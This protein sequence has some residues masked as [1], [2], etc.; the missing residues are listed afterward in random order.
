M[1]LFPAGP[2]RSFHLKSVTSR[3]QRGEDRDLRAAPMQAAR[4]PESLFLGREKPN[5]A[6]NEHRGR[7]ASTHDS[8]CPFPQGG[9]PRSPARACP[10]AGHVP[11]RHGGARDRQN[12]APRPSTT[13]LRRLVVGVGPPCKSSNVDELADESRASHVGRV[14]F[15]VR[16]RRTVTCSTGLARRS[17]SEPYVRCHPVLGGCSSPTDLLVQKGQPR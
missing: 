14:V 4:P 6:L 1:A 17:R 12:D 2:S 3:Q 5:H 13:R 15:G 7:H 9:T 11:A 10:P 16:V 8:S